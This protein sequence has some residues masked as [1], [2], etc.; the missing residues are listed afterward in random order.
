MAA[1]S[2]PPVARERDAAPPARVI[3]WD[4]GGAHLKA[5]LWEAGALRQVVQLPCPLWQGVDRLREALAEAAARLGPADRHAATMTGELADIFA[6]RAEGVSA[7][8]AVLVETLGPAVRLYAGARSF[9]APG[10]AAGL[11]DA[12]A[13][14]NWHATAALAARFVPDGLMVDMG[15]TTTDIVPLSAGAVAARGHTDAAR[16]ACGELVYTGLV[17]TPLMALT[18][19]AP[20]A[21]AWTTLAAEHFA[22]A[23][24]VHRL[25]DSLPDGADLLPTA[26]GRDR[27]PAS[28]RGR[29]ARMVGRDAA[30]AGESAWRD[31]AA[32]LAEQQMRQLE[33]A[34]RLVL[35]A[36]PT[37]RHVVAAG[38]G[39]AVV[40]RLAQRLGCRC[41]PFSS[42]VPGEGAAGACAPA[43]AM[44]LL[45]AEEASMGS[46][47]AGPSNDPRGS[48]EPLASDA[49]TRGPFDP[50][51]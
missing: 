37:G 6:S 22:T 17:R 24:D 30:E 15:S 27:S 16:L 32:W 42:L 9:V 40:A 11:A 25:L 7:I 23:A 20:F 4:V 35:S 47:S 14:A 36:G 31:L 28:S 44:A 29:L 12:V 1:I 46:P 21:G 34:A 3:G 50:M 2:A 48:S 8:A 45:G 41:T 43:V 33:D 10:E 49:R 5:A 19:R 51:T 26:D 13:S 38:V 18:H 39:H